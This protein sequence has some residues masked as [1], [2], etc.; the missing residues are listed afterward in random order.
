MTEM[1]NTEKATLNLSSQM[2]VKPGFKKPYTTK[3]PNIDAPQMIDQPDLI[4]NTGDN[5]NS[6]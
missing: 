2:T 6:L 1:Q 5:G 4:N 3:K